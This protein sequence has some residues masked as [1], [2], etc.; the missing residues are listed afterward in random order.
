M[1]VV[2]NKIVEKIQFAENH[3]P[4]FTTNAVA[5]GTTSAA[6]TDLATKTTAQSCNRSWD[7]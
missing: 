5:I 1:P 3:V 2:P 4:T 6:C 7:R